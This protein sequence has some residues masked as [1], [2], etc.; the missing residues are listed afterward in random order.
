MMFNGETGV[1]QS[2]GDS[3][4]TILFS[5]KDACDTCGL[6]VVCAPGKE[7]ERILSLPHAGEYHIGQSVRIEE[8]SN[9]ELHLSLIQFGYPMLLFITGLLIGYFFPLQAFLP[10]ELSGFLVACVGLGFSFFSARNMVSR[11][12]ERIPDKYLR[13]VTDD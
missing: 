7:S 2:V 12:V 4:V 3:R 9:L 11:L 13:I 8:L 5:K 10:R 6:K 1:I